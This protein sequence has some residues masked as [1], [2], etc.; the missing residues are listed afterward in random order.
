M[1]ASWSGWS[2]FGM[3]EL[4]NLPEREGIYQL[5]CVDGAGV[6]ITIARLNNND[7]DGIIYIGS[8]D[9]LRK[10]LKGFWR[11]I[12]IRDRSRHA[13]AWTYCSFGY[14]SIFPPNQIEF[15]YQ[16]TR[17]KV[18]TEF[19]LLLNYRKE[20]MDLPPLNSNR[21]PYPGDWKARIRKVFGRP[22]LPA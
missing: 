19:G 3:K 13:A 4:S 14:D 12:E 20:F 9:N 5:R 18:T 11:T 17:N 22:P 21:P 15:T 16:V 7:P 8:S 2:R 6:P 1:K 10:R